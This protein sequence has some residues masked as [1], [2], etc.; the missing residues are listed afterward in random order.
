MSVIARFG[1]CEVDF[2]RV[3]IRLAGSLVEDP[4]LRAQLKR[5]SGRGIARLTWESIGL[6]FES[7]LVEAV[8][9]RAHRAAERRT[10]VRVA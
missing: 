10:V 6:A 1:Q 8:T 9:G 3:E 5:Q 7:V 4:G 2:D